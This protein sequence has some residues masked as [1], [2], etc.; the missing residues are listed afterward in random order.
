MGAFWDAWDKQNAVRDQRGMAGL[1]QAQGLAGLMRQA[2]SEQEMQRVRGLL[3]DTSLSPEARAQ[4]LMQLGPTGIKLAGDL[5][6]MQEQQARAGKLK[7]EQ[8]FNRD[9]APKFMQAAQPAVT[10]NMTP[11]GGMMGFQSGEAEDGGNQGLISPAKP[12]GLDYGGLIEAKA[13]AGL[14]YPESFS[15]HRAQQLERTALRQ[16]RAQSVD[17]QIAATN[18]RAQD[19]AATRI[20]MAQTRADNQKDNIRLAASLRQSVQGPRVTPYSDIAKLESDVKNGL[21]SRDQADVALK[22]LTAK[23]EFTLS[24]DQF[25]QARNL[26]SEYEKHPEVVKANA[27]EVKVR[28][29][30]E[31]MLS[32][33]SGNPVSPAA[34]MGI[35]KTYLGA[36]TGKGDNI[37]IMDTKAL[38]KLP[39]LASMGDGGRVGTSLKSFFGGAQLDTSTRQEMVNAIR[40]RYKTLDD[41]RGKVKKDKVTIGGRHNLTEDLIF[42]TE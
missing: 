15:N 14:L 3:S 17:L 8:D 22:S 28:P 4:G 35:A 13:A 38:A 1:Q 26:R 24:K 37:K 5:A 21:I 11:T 29:I 6:S 34:D 27:L 16:D 32:L 10:G 40:S 33:K 39:E 23:K 19:A 30:A 25:T 20:E 36:L 18:Q 41:F 42:A 7:A 9:V 2:Q 12:G 31:Y